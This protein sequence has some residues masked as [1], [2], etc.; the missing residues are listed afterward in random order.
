LILKSLPPAVYAHK[1]TGSEERTSNQCRDD[2]FGKA[3]TPARLNAFSVPQDE[4]NPSQEITRRYGRI[5]GRHGV[6]AGHDSCILRRTLA[7]NAVNK[8]AT[9]AM[10]QDDVAFG[11]GVVPDALDHDFVS[12]HYRRQHAPSRDLQAQGAGRA[13]YFARQLT[14]EGVGLIRWLRR[15]RHDELE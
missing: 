13:Q 4:S 3:Q 10:E 1:D 15:K 2:A 12:G 7:H 5:A 14:F 8:E 9:V 6:P 11:N